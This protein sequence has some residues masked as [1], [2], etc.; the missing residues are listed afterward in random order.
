MIHLH[1]TIIEQTYKRRRYN[2]IHIVVQEGEKWGNG[3]HETSRGSRVGKARVHA[4]TMYAVSD[5]GTQ[6]LQLP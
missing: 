5:E 6:Y 3:E 2:H 1:K 4:F